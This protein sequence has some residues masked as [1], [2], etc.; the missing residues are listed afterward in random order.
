[1][2][3]NDCGPGV[4]SSNKFLRQRN[5]WIP[6]ILNRSSV[7]G[8]R[9]K[10]LWSA[11]EV[12]LPNS[13]GQSLPRTEVR[14]DQKQDFIIYMSVSKKLYWAISAIAAITTEARSA[15]HMYHCPFQ[16]QALQW[17]S[18]T[19]LGHTN[20]KEGSTCFPASMPLQR[21]VVCPKIICLNTHIRVP[22]C[23]QNHRCSYRK[24]REGNLTLF[25]LFISSQNIKKNC[26]L[27]W[28]SLAA[29]KST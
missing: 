10:N 23:N 11:Q 21:Q 8:T 14:L 20:R 29:L 1:M 12:H 6:G 27:P 2:L 24:L 13:C 16:S 19:H 4:H 28:T 5:A 22:F 7:L 25:L 15:W 26:Q 17:S 9:K 18:R 3:L